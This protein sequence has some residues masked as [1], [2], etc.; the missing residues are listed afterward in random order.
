ML[1]AHMTASPGMLPVGSPVGRGPVDEHHK[2]RSNGDILKR[3][4]SHD[5]HYSYVQ[6]V[7]SD[8]M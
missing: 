3:K 2:E 7:V 6:P 8:Q 4:L 5:E 1:S